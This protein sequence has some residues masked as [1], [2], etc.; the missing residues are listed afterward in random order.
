MLFRS[1]I[2][3]E[4]N[5]PTSPTKSDSKGFKH[6]FNKLKRR[7]KHSNSVFEQSNPEPGFIGG[8]AFTGASSGS[9]GAGPNPS[10][11]NPLQQ[12][13]TAST[14]V[15]LN[16]NP[17]H[18]PSVSSLSGEEDDRGRAVQRRAIGVSAVSKES[19]LEEAR[20]TF[21]ERLAPPPSFG[22]DAA[23]GR[24]GSPIRD[25]RFLEQL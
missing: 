21:D 2:P 20:D 1:R 8:A 7:S 23:E 15:N 22:S 13:N 6:L 19:D 18:S 11:P 9:A 3:S 12:T 25:S 10:T 16:S 4:P 5:S 24:R 14:A 17:Y